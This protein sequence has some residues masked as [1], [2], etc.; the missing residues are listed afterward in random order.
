MNVKRLQ[1]ALHYLGHYAEPVYKWR[2]SIGRCPLCGV[3]LFLSVGPDPFLTRCLSCTANVTNLSLI[4]VIETQLGSTAFAKDGYE[5]SSY[6]STLIWLEK[7]LRSVTK[8]EYF[9]G[10]PLGEPV[11]E[12]LNEDVQRLSFPDESF[13][14][15]TSNQV[16]EHVPHVIAGF[17]ECYRVLRPAGSLIFSVPLYDTP[18]TLHNA[19]LDDGLVKFLGEPE[20]HSSRLG[21]PNSAPVFWR[22]SKRDICQRVMQAGFPRAELREAFIAPPQRIPSL[23]VCAVK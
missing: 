5:L 14:L 6:G 18:S 22:F 12:V 8:S 3:R 1:A 7:H 21:G 11:N 13:D 23:V 19:V 15:V 20:Y 2:T 4:P 17:R 16:F 9:P 10:Y